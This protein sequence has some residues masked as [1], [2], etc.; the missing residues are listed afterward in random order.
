MAEVAVQLLL[1]AIGKSSH[2]V[3]QDTALTG[4]GDGSVWKMHASRT[5]WSSVLFVISWTL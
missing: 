1:M 3:C 5:P 4:A 2:K